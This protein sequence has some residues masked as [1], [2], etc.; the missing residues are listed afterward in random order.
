MHIGCYASL[1]SCA[2]A[3]ISEGLNALSNGPP[4]SAEQTTAL[5][6]IRAGHCTHTATEE[7]AR[8]RLGFLRLT[9]S[10]QANTDTDSVFAELAH[11]RFCRPRPTAVSGQLDA[12]RQ[13]FVDRT[14]EVSLH[15]ASKAAASAA[16]AKVTPTNLP[17]KSPKPANQFPTNARLPLRPQHMRAPQPATKPAGARGHHRRSNCV[18]RRVDSCS[19][20]SPFMRHRVQQRSHK[21]ERPSPK[22]DP[23]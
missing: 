20:S 3:A 15:V 9:K 21:R 16:F 12:L 8:T 10:G 13:A 14:L 7:A 19:P 1:Y 6:L 23:P 18:A 2:N 22:L 17:A 11:Q 4:L 5:A